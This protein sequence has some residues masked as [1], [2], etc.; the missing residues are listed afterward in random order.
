MQRFTLLL[1]AS[2]F[3]TVPGKAH[4]QTIKLRYGQIPSTL[5]TVSALRF[6]LA[7]HK[8]FFTRETLPWKFSR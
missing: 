2:I 4:G 7:Q 6:H 5:K 8:G 1:V 3:L